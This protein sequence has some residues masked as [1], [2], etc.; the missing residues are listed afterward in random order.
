MNNRQ[1]NIFSPLPFQSRQDLRGRVGFAL[2]ASDRYCSALHCP[3]TSE[4]TTETRWAEERPTHQCPLGPEVMPF[5]VRNGDQLKQVA[6]IAFDRGR[7][8][9][10]DEVS[11]VKRERRCKNRVFDVR[12][13]KKLPEWISRENGLEEAPIER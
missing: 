10:I 6:I 11:E 3:K 4:N 2:N 1:V 9:R 5:Q 13:C 12:K 8:K 7:A